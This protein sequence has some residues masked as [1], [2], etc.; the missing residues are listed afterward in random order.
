MLPS[1]T[2]D[3]KL[4]SDLYNLIFIFAVITFV[5]VEG[6]LIYSAVKF[7]RRS[8]AE[9]PAQDHGSR[10]LELMWTVIPA[11][12][13]SVIFGLSVDTMSKL[14]GTGSL[15]NPVPHTHA[16][17]DSEARRRVENAQPVDLVIDV[18]GR[19]WVWQFKYPGNEGVTASEELVLPVGKRVRL[20]MTA[21]DVIHAWWIPQLGPM[22]YV[23]PGE[24]SY[25]WI[26]VNTP[27]TYKGQCNMYCGAAHANMLARVRVVTQS[28]FDDWY[29]KQSASN[30]TQT[31]AS[32]P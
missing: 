27:G 31:T 29:A 12:L 15:S 21:A 17:T 20:D 16:I 14:T 6:L 7:R 19:Q 11:L 9:M 8:E 28:E 30:G 26:D 5:L 25:V 4:I 13:V 10:T 22:I 1:A 24:M 18:T 32:K 23:N 3:A 2:Q